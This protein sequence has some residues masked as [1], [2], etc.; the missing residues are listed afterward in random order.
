MAICDLISCRDVR[1]LRTEIRKKKGGNVK[2]IYEEVLKTNDANFF[3]KVFSDLEYELPQFEELNDQVLALRNEDMIKAFMALE[4]AHKRAVSFDACQEA[5]LLEFVSDEFMVFYQKNRQVRLHCENV[6]SLINQEI[7][8]NDRLD[9]LKREITYRPLLLEEQ[10]ALVTNREF[11]L[12]DVHFDVRG[13][14]PAT[15]AYYC[16]LQKYEKDR[17]LRADK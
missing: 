10:C 3:R 16:H 9:I 12:L 17:K 2:H 4:D 7:K 14:D 6:I 15:L 5:T 11:L 1:G 8:R 13:L